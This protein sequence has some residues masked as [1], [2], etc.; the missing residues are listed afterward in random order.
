VATS[1]S[2]HCA[3][4]RLM[5]ISLTPVIVMVMLSLSSPRAGR[6]KIKAS[7][8]ATRI[9]VI[10]VFIYPSEFG[11]TLLLPCCLANIL[12]DFSSENKAS[13][14]FPKILIYTILSPAYRQAF[15]GRIMICVG[16]FR[17]IHS[18]TE[19]EKEFSINEKLAIL[20]YNWRCVLPVA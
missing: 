7:T 4:S 13:N 18:S 10:T 5:E 9:L 12:R 11:K 17:N 2:S 3:L 6:E 14:S 8:V 19:S 1:P 20:C 16:K 15:P